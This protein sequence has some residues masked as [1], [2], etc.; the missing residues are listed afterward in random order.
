MEGLTDMQMALLLMVIGMGMVFII[1][2]LIIYLSQL[3]IIVVNKF[4]PEEAPVAKNKSVQAE[5]PIPANVQNAIKAAV[6]QVAPG[7]I[8]TKITKD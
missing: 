6:N 1:L 7:A 8:V 3:M 4:A 5:A 2:Y